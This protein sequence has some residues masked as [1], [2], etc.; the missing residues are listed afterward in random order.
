M[1]DEAR[2][3]LRE[4][5]AQAVAMNRAFGPSRS[6]EGFIVRIDAF[7]SRPQLRG[8]QKAAPTGYFQP[9]HL[10]GGWRETNTIGKPNRDVSA[11]SSHAEPDTPT[12]KQADDH[13]APSGSASNLSSAAL[14]HAGHDSGMPEAIPML[15]DGW[16][17]PIYTQAEYEFL[18]AYALSLRSQIGEVE[19][20]AERYRWLR[21]I[22]YDERLPRVVD[23]IAGCIG[24]VL[25]GN[26]LDAAIDAAIAAPEHS[27]R[28]EEE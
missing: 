26:D 27:Q 23:R 4:A 28:E 22:D 17:D 11:G 16:P 6:L 1:T 19:K 3:L 13:G 10:G 5:R 14:P 2:E 18:R 12:G 20:D 7:F 9:A 25:E 21:K 24:H 15:V 8:E